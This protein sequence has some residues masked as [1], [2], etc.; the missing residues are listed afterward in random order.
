MNQQRTLLRVTEQLELDKQE[1]TSKLMERPVIVNVDFMTEITEER[2]T[3]KGPV[4][5]GQKPLRYVRQIVMHNNT[6]FDIC[7]T[8]DS[9]VAAL[10]EAG[11]SIVT[12]TR[13]PDNEGRTG[14]IERMVDEKSSIIS[15]PEEAA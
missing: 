2:L 11:V 5:I 9:I 8:L 15:L 13:D 1:E 14:I 7:E 12:V 10:T 6:R 3:R 4:I